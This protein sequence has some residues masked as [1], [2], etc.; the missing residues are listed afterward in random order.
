[1]YMTKRTEYSLYNALMTNYE[2]QFDKDGVRGERIAKRLDALSKI[3]LTNDLG[4][5]RPGFSQE[6]KQAK[7]LVMSWMEEA[8]LDVEMDGAGNVIGRLAG[9]NNE[10]KSIA[11]GSHVDSV[12]NGG[13]F[14]GPLGV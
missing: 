7:A 5:N 12:P 3:G 10:L 11:S 13:H 9:K 2:S 6:E 1:M 4:S 8:G 14:D